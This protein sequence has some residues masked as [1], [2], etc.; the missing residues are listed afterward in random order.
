MNKQSKPFLFWES[1]DKEYSLF[2][3]LIEE[4]SLS[5]LKIYTPEGQYIGKGKIVP[6]GRAGYIVFVKRGETKET[7]YQ[8][9][10]YTPSR[11][12]FQFGDKQLD[13]YKVK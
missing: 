4:D 10:D 13:L 7:I 8:I 1:E 3:S 5:D 2:H 6:S 9:L 12:L 11:L